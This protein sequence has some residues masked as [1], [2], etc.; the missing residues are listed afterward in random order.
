MDDKSLMDQLYTLKKPLTSRFRKKYVETLALGILQYCY[1]EK[2]DGF[3]VH[4]A[5]DI[6]DGNKLIGIEVTEAVS[7]EQ[8]QIEG[9]FVKYRL[10]SR[11][12]EKERRKRIIEENGASVNQLGLTYPVK[13]GDDEKQ[14]FQNAIRKKMEKLEAYRTQ[15]YQK[16]G[17][18]VF[19]DE[20]PIPVK[21]EELKD[22]FDE[23]MNGYNDKYDIIYFVH[24]FGLIEYDV[25]TDEVQVIPIERSIYNKLRYDARVKIGI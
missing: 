13:N 20:P 11:T 18:F 14:I 16:V 5:P 19:Y 22:Y 4:D 9:E 6:S 8:A 25:L 23:A 24:S 10:E 7:D 12:E 1:K 17:L 21:L 2:Y 3:E 15:G